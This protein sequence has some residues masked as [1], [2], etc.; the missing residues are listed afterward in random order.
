MSYII[1]GFKAG[2][3]EKYA[4]GKYDEWNQFF[5]V[6]NINSELILDFR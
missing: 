4:E 2:I 1:V 6:L 5:H 3:E